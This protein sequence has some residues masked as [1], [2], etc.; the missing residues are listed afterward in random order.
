MVMVEN[1]QKR[2]KINLLQK[3]E[4]FLNQFL[5]WALTVGRLLVIITET[6][7]LS[8]F[9]YRF[10]LDMRIVDLHDKIRTDNI[11]VTNFKSGE[12]TFRNIQS[13][14]ALAKQY[15]SSSSKILTILKDVVNMG[16]NNI[17]FTSIIVKTDTL[18]ITAQAPSASLLYNF[19]Q[20]LKNYSSVASVSIDQVENKP[21]LGTASI[22]ITAK[23]KLIP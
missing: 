19:T 13:K 14:L 1:K 18:L 12:N 2:R 15:D 3:Q 5:S 7:A 4:T 10:L 17:S 22:S 21:S 9:L 11:I 20:E 16:R 8:V 6:L 23:L